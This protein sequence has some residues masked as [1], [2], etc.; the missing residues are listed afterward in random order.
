MVIYSLPVTTF[1]SATIDSSVLQQQ[2]MSSCLA[3]LQAPAAMNV[4]DPYDLVRMQFPF[5]RVLPQQK[6]KQKKSLVFMENAGGSQCPAVVIDAM[7]EYMRFCYAQPG[8]R[9]AISTLAEHVIKSARDF[10]RVFVNADNQGDVAFGASTSQLLAM[11]GICYGR[12]LQ[13]GDE[14]IVHEA[15]HEANVAPWVRMA[16]QAGLSLK[17][18][19][20]NHESFESNLDELGQLLSPRTRI[21]AVTHVSNLLGEVLDL[22]KV[23]RYVKERVGCSKVRVVAD[24][25]AY[26]PHRALDVA[27]WGVDWYVFS[28]Y[29]VYGPHMAVLFGTMEAFMDVKEVAPNFDFISSGD[30]SKKFE[31]GGVCHEGCAEAGCRFRSL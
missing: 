4:D 27:K 26:A 7:A 8:S 25:V 31:L 19:L 9:Y 16:E 1:F 21:V 23:V 18:W 28:T 17:F 3:S 22:E 13:R 5:F 20:L 30:L 12:V 29:K 14:V 10:V 15:N 24:G 11:L 6:Q 2:A